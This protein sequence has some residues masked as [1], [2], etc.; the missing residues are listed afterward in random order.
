MLVFNP[1]MIVEPVE[2]AAAMNVLLHVLQALLVLLVT[3][4]IWSAVNQLHR[5]SQAEANAGNGA[6]TTTG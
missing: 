3:A 6:Q 5:S 1:N 4:L 2:C